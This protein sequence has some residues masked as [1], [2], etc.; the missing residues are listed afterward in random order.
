MCLFD[1]NLYTFKHWRWE[2]DRIVHEPIIEGVRTIPG[3]EKY[4][5][6]DIREFLTFKDNAVIKRTLKTIARKSK[7]F[8]DSFQSSSEGSFDLRVMKILKYFSMNINYQLPDLQQQV[9]KKDVWLFPDET[10][11][12][13]NGDCEDLSFLLAS[14][15]L[16]SG[17][18]SYVVRVALGKLYD[19]KTKISKDHAWVMYKN[20]LGL[21]LL[22]DPVLFVQEDKKEKKKETQI[23]KL[24]RDRKIEYI[25][26]Y[27]LNDEHLWQIDRNTVDGGFKDYYK[28]REFWVEFNPTFAASVH[29]SIFDNALSELSW[30]T[31]QWIK[32]ISFAM[33]TIPSYDPRDHFDNGYIEESWNLIKERLAEKS[34]S[35][36]AKAAHSIAD[37]YAHTTYACFAKKEDDGNLSIPKD[38]N[39]DGLFETTPDYGTPKFDTKDF[40]KFSINEEDTGKQPQEIIDPNKRVSELNAKIIISGRFAQPKDPHQKFL[41]KNFVPYPYKFLENAEDYQWRKYLPHHNE[42]AVDDALSSNAIPTDHKLY[43]DPAIFQEQYER[44]KEAAIKHIKMVYNNWK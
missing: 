19:H 2:G 38:G 41:E 16:A 33:D 40:T 5:D 34:I 20:D 35:G 29:N 10:L 15:L 3:T 9:C 11:S 28:S 25:P 7:K 8:S 31:R 24:D 36:L 13:K 32:C 18:S 26:Y 4:Y 44:R 14:L 27:V 23:N 17:I 12:I 21:W 39:T 30:F 6:I 37:F 22:I 43:T 1:T 42:I